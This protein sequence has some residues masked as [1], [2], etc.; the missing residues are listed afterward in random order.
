[1]HIQTFFTQNAWFAPGEA[2]ADSYSIRTTIKAAIAAVQ[3]FAPDGRGHGVLRLQPMLKSETRRQNCY[4]LRLKIN[5]AIQ[6]YFKL[7]RAIQ[8]DSGDSS[9]RTDS[10]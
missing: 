8:A 3:I 4:E 2:V 7:I 6:A 10:A 5:Q 1:M 9:I